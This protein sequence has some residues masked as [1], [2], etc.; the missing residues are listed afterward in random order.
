VLVDRT[1]SI[2]YDWEAGAP[3]PALPTD[4]FGARWTLLLDLDEPAT[5][6]A[7]SIVAQGGV[8]M[9]IGETLV[10]DDWAHGMHREFVRGVLPAGQYPIVIEYMNVSGPASITVVW[11]R[12]AWLTL[13]PTP[14]PVASGPLFRR[15]PTWPFRSA[16]EGS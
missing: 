9:Y 5:R 2:D 12:P 15:L 10:V 8:R 6:Y 14:T 4:G 3:D 16:P 1:T 7:V 13:T 11:A